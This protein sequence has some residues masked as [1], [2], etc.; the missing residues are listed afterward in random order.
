[1][2]LADLKYLLAYLLPLSAFISIAGEGWISYGTVIFSFIVIPFI[3]QILPVNVV[4]LGEDEVRIKDSQKFFDIL[5]FL[6]VPIIFGLLYFYFQSI[7][8]FASTSDWLGKTISVGLVLSACGINVAHELGHKKSKISQLASKMLLLPSL[9]M[10]FFIEHN[11]GH[12][13]RVATPEDPATSRK[14]E[15]LYTFWFRSVI[16]GYK[17]AWTLSNQ[18]CTRNG[19]SVF[20]LHNEMIQF[21]IIQLA[22][23]FL[24]FFFYGNLALISFIMMAVISFLNLENINYIEHYGLMRKK[25]PNGKYEKVT[26]IH[27]WNSDHILGRIM[28]YELTRHSDHHYKAN[29]KYQILQ[30]YRE[31]PQLPLGYPTSILAAMIPPLWFKIMHPLLDRYTA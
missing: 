18:A 28:L 14:N 6:N 22:T 25:K 15:I 7:G 10:H 31:S 9:Y 30:H 4:N 23:L 27:S 11:L 13:L 17:H 12:H 29:K 8:S 21:S 24:I 1:M 5:L 19:K 3:E 16:G 20:S 2:K 26:Q